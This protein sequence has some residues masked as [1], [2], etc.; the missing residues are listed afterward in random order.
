MIEENKFSSKKIQ[1]SNEKNEDSNVKNKLN[2][3]CERT[4]FY[5]YN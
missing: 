1:Q 5:S 2:F 4:L 3:R